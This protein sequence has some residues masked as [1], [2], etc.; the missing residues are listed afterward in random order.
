MK[1][2]HWSDEDLIARLY[3]LEPEDKHLEEC[4]ECGRRWRALLAAR[5]RFLAEP[6][7]PAG[8][9]ARQRAQIHAV[10]DQ[11]AQPWWRRAWA[12]VTAAAGMVLLALLIVRPAPTPQPSIASSEPQVFAEV[13]AL[14]E[15]EPEAVTPIYALF[16]VRQ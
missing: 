11:W 15:S 16:E 10:L 4:E 3:G 13:Y 7:L 14:V 12:P 1:Q 9:L 8:F 2:R 6:E 5:E